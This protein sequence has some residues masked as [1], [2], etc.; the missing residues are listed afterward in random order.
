VTHEKTVPHGSET[1]KSMLS[2]YNYHTDL[3]QQ[4]HVHYEV[5]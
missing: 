5:R 1:L 4:V 2:F 3:M